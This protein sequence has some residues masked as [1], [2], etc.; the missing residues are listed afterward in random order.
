MDY[1]NGD[2]FKHE[3]RDVSSREELR[4]RYHLRG[5]VPDIIPFP[6]TV[7]EL[8]QSSADVR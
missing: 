7:V 4:E 3:F 8:A 6:I 5:G 2:C 1:P